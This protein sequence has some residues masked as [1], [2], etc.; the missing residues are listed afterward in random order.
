MSTGFWTLER[1]G[2]A[3]RSELVGRAPE[4]DASIASIST[5]T[6]EKIGRAH[7]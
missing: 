4:G 6:R 1:I 3:L 7:V 2:D 5:D